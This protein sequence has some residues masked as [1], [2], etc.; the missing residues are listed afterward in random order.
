MGSQVR[1]APVVAIVGATGAVGVEMIG[2]LE[3]RRF[4]LKELRLF[5]SPRSAGKQLEF[6]GAPITVSE[7]TESS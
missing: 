7:L 3:R 6:R 2:C 5:A 1:P 4:P